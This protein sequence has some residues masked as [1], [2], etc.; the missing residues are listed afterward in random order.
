VN[1]KQMSSE[2]E[3][4]VGHAKGPRQQSRPPKGVDGGAGGVAGEDSY[5]V[6]KGWQAK[7]TEFDWGAHKSKG[8][9]AKRAGVKREGRFDKNKKPII[10]SK[11][12]RGKRTEVLN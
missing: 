9:K 2:G 3:E 4:P 10:L 1:H 6:A 12:K 11:R 8:K 7:D 5:E